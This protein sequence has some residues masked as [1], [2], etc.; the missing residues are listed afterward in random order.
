MAVG[1]RADTLEARLPTPRSTRTRCFSVVELDVLTA[2]AAV[3]AGEFAAVDSIRAGLLIGFKSWPS[4]VIGMLSKSESSRLPMT[5]SDAP[6]LLN[7]SLN[8]CCP[9]SKIFHSAV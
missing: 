7:E 4:G 2:E 9:D 1:L 8:T 3:V 5:I 6:R